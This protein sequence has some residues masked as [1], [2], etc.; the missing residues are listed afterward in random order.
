VDYY[1]FYSERF[2]DAQHQ[3]EADVRSFFANVLRGDEPAQQ[4]VV[5]STAT[6]SRRG[7]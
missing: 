4:N 2:T 3:F 7:G 6:V 1:R 5:W